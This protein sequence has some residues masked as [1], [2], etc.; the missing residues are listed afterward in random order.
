MHYPGGKGQSYHK[1]VNLMPPHEV[2]IET[3]L[4][5]GSIMGNKRPAK[6]N[7]GIEIDPRVIEKW[8]NEEQV[9]FELVHGDAIE[10]L[11]KYKFTGNEL[12]YCD[13]PYLRETRRSYKKIYKYDYT[14]EQ[15]NKLL[16]L[17]KALPCKVMISGYQSLLYMEAL[18][19]W[20]LQSFDATIRKRT[21]TEYI[22]MNYAPPI[23]L[24]DYS[25]LGS[26]FRERDR[27]K[28]KTKR[29]VTRLKSM[30]V[31]EQQ[32]LFSALQTVNQ[33]S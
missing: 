6:R 21:S 10:Y 24:H 3:H 7:I 18:K 1:F 19:E 15:H 16:D 11:K 31:L 25:Y 2:Y 20:H 8:T 12:I 23:Q 14:P 9:N 22:W 28:Q 5:G 29:W 27:I 33:K 13:P 26:N 30:P 4:G 17:I 32:A